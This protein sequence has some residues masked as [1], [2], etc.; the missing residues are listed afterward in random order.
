MIKNIK[1]KNSFNQIFSLSAIGLVL[2]ILL[3]Q[4]QYTAQIVCRMLIAACLAAGLDICV[5]V[6][7]QL[8]LGHG[9]FMAVGAYSCALVTNA[10]PSGIGVAISILLAIVLSTAFAFL[11]GYIILG[12]RGDYLA[13]CTI[14]LGEIVRVF[15]E[16]ADFLGGAGGFYN[17]PKFTSPTNAYAVYI[18]SIGTAI[19]FTNSKSGFLAKTVGQDEYASESVGV[20]IKKTKVG[21]FVISAVITAFGGILYAGLLGFV[22]PKD[23]GYSRSIDIL[24]AVILGGSGTIVGPVL[25]AMCIE[26][27]F[28]LFQAASVFRMI[29]YSLAIIIFTIV[30]YKKRGGAK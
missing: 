10:L 28:A 13:V 2:V 11:V 23:F 6:A 16:N 19:L 5:G 20:N 9:V 30:K 7:G 29:L 27:F 26:A 4:R 3:G 22:S 8:S 21:A 12:L 24:A 25:A 14:G 18:L 17:I 15:L 1:N